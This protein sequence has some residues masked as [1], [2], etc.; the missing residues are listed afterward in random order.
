M[1]VRVEVE[2]DSGRYW[3][4]FPSHAEI[5][6]LEDEKWSDAECDCHCPSCW[7]E[8]SE[9]PCGNDYRQEWGDPIWPGT[10][11]TEGLK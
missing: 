2:T 8:N 11:D 4:T 5:R 9:C 7:A 6:L 1:S 3:L 10:I